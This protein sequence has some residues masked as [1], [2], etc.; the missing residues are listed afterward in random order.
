MRKAKS[1]E[2]AKTLFNRAGDSLLKGFS[3]D[4]SLRTRESRKENIKTFLYRTSDSILQSFADESLPVTEDK[5]EY[6]S[7]DGS[8]QQVSKTLVSIA[9]TANQVF[10]IISRK[11]DHEEINETNEIVNKAAS[12]ED[13][14]RLIQEALRTKGI[15]TNMAALRFIEQYK[16]SL[17]KSDNEQYYK[18]QDITPGD[19]LPRNTILKEK[20]GYKWNEPSAMSSQRCGNL[21]IMNVDYQ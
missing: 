21:R 10:E 6:S 8:I 15:T 4:I 2:N 14:L 1:E 20:Y 7:I 19:F 5:S 17:Q 9:T 16:K 13:E 3:S 12:Y 18:K 11:V